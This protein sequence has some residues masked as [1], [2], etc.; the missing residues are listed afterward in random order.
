MG[1]LA[2]GCMLDDGTLGGVGETAGS[3]DPLHHACTR[4]KHPSL[5]ERGGLKMLVYTTQSPSQSC[6]ADPSSVCVLV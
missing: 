2:Q 6:R 1:A 4:D 3:A 5:C